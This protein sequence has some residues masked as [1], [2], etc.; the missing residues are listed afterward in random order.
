MPTTAELKEQRRKAV[1]AHNKRQAAAAIASRA[2]RQQTDR[3][4]LCPKP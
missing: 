2:A 4:G 1:L 3:T